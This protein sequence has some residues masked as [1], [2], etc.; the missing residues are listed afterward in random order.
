MP[1]ATRSNATDSGS[2][3]TQ[4]GDKIRTAAGPQLE[5]S[6]RA[7]DGATDPEGFKPTK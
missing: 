3:A 4:L 5:L 1:S 6:N 2:A 7:A